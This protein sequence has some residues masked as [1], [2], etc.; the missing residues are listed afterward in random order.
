MFMTSS[1]YTLGAFPP[2]RNILN[3]CSASDYSKVKNKLSKAQWYQTYKI[4]MVTFAVAR[5]SKY[6]LAE[7]L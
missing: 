7:H 3:F 2:A 5:I 4:S 1:K 6:Y